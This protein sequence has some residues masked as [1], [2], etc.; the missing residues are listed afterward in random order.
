MLDLTKIKAI[1]LDLDD[2]LWPVWPAIYRA[3]DELLQ[4]LHTHAPATAQRYSST[5]ALRAVRVQLEAARPDLRHD[6]SAMRRESIRLALRQ[7]GDD[8]ALAEPAFE[9]FF[10]ARQRVDLFEDA[11]PALEQLAARFPLV[12]LSN[13]NADVHRVGIG[14]HFSASF[15]AHLF[16]VAK[17]DPRIFHAA[18][19]AVG[20]APHEVLH[21]G[22]DALLDVVAAV[23]AGMQ[24]VWLNR[25]GHAWAHATE[26]HLTVADL[27]A[28]SALWVTQ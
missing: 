15:S 23:D 5:E 2:T 4:W 1:S 22:D 3:E 28:L 24:A 25:H 11:L 12:A 7:S 20:V 27:G 8:G 21:V 26:P 13:G 17:P 6:L 14:G 16:G 19:Q 10:A 18:A 9:V